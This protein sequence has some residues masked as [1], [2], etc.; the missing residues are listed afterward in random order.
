MITPEG[1]AVHLRILIGRQRH[2]DRRPQCTHVSRSGR[3]AFDRIACRKADSTSPKP[4][5]TWRLQRNPTRRW[6]S[7]TP[8]NIAEEAR[9]EVQTTFRTTARRQGISHGEGTLPARLQRTGSPSGLPAALQEKIFYHQ[10][11]GYEAAV[12]RRCS[13]AGRTTGIVRRRVRRAP[14]L[15]ALLGRA[16]WPRGRRVNVRR[17]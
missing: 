5:S 4:L 14:L 8:K 13:P 7:S 12:L 3:L 6:G 1:A 10:R 15:F 16:L 17:F 11:P 9:Q 2:R